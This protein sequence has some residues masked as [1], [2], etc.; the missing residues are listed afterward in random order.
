MVTTQSIT[1]VKTIIKKARKK[2]KIIGFIPTM[3]ALHAGH[4]SLVKAAKKETDFVVVSIFVN[5]RQFSPSED[6]RRYPKPF[7]NDRRL[8]HKEGVGLIFHPKVKTLYPDDFSCSVEETALS[9]YLC[10]VW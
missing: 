6:Y 10:G 4:L 5:P 7:G 8:L 1:K 3:G 2:N 9:R